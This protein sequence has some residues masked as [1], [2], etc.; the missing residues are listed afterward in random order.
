MNNLN[1]RA[2]VI[3]DRLGNLVDCLQLNDWSTNHISAEEIRNLKPNKMRVFQPLVWA[4]ILI[5]EASLWDDGIRAKIEEVAK[6]PIIVAAC[7]KGMFDSQK[8]WREIIEKVQS[9]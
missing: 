2:T 8:I 1:L 9:S 5:I 7:E 4:D 3:G 6:M